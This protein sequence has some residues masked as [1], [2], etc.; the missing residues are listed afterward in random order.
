MVGAIGENMIQIEHIRKLILE[1][2]CERPLSCIDVHERLQNKVKSREQVK[3]AIKFLWLKNKLGR[4]R[5]GSNYFY[6]SKDLPCGD[7]IQQFGS[8]L[9]GQPKKFVQLS[10]GTLIEAT[11]TDIVNK[12]KLPELHIDNNRITFD[13]PKCRI[14][15]EL[16]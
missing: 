4:I 3:S 9:P 13:H 2:P 16:K 5:E 11:I 6:W 7:V 10:D 14:V 8:S 12:E 1:T 15:I